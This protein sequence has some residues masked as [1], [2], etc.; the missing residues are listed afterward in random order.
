M[1]ISK[2]IFEKINNGMIS[3]IRITLYKA[4]TWKVIESE[5]NVLDH[6]SSK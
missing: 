4:P 6:T 3:N 5:E 1:E 2:E